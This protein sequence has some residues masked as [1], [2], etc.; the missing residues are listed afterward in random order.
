MD[1]RLRAFW[2]PGLLMGVLSMS[3]LL[4]CVRLGVAPLTF[5]PHWHHPWQFYLPW[6][7]M[8]P[9]LGALRAYWSRRA[10]GR[11]PMQLAAGLFPA[12][13]LT[14]LGIIGLVIDIIVDVGTGRHTIWHSLCG[15]GYFP[16]CWNLAPGAALLLGTW[17]FLEA[18][19]G[20]SSGRLT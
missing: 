20:K 9:F 3:L 12:M 17:L 13:A 6:L 11:T 4:V 7:A 14:A 8:L 5:F 16:V 15:L 1:K 2:L 18:R 10:G 19:R